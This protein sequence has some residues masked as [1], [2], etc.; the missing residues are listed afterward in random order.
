MTTALRTLI[1]AATSGTSQEQLEK[2]VR[3]AIG[4]GLVRK[5][6]LVTA[7]KQDPRLHRFAEVLDGIK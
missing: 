4:R 6:K 1:D 2:A 5:P 7:A 3:E